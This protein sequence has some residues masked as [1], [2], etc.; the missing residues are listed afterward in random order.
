[1]KSLYET[2][3]IL[4]K[5]QGNKLWGKQ[6]NKFNKD[7]WAEI[8]RIEKSDPVQYCKKGKTKEI[9]KISTGET[10]KNITQCAL[11]NGMHRNTL[12][13]MLS[14]GYECDFRLC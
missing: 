11:A 1:M 12:F 5:D 3:E 7:D 14:R 4:R 13:A 6:F 2:I 10:F 9:M 8:E